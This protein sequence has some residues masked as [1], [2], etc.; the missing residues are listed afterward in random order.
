VC[1]RDWTCNGFTDSWQTQGARCVNLRT[2]TALRCD[3]KFDQ[4]SSYN[5]GT[6]TGDATHIALNYP[7]LGGGTKTHHCYP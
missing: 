4:G 1:D 3:G 6:W 5:V 2:A 7:M